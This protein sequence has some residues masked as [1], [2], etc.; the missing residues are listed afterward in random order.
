[1]TCR[2]SGLSPPRACARAH[3]GNQA[4]EP[5]RRRTRGRPRTR[6]ARQGVLPQAGGGENG[7]ERNRMRER[8]AGHPLSRR[9]GAGRAPAQPC[10]GLPARGERRGGCLSACFHAEKIM[11]PTRNLYWFL[12]SRAAR[13]HSSGSDRAAIPRRSGPVAVSSPATGNAVGG[14]PQARRL[15]FLAA[16]GPPGTRGRW[17]NMTKHDIP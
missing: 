17:R 5:R 2:W 12:L 13:L 10:P 6:Y 7:K 16:A 1:M 3:A 15:P 9:M 8:H 14:S 4:R 11:E